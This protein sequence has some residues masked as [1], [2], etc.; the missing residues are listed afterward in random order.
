[1]LAALD[2][3]LNVICLLGIYCIVLEIRTLHRMS[4]EILSHFNHNNL[5][6][7]KGES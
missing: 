1:M 2:F 6:N 4:E 7:H 3:A 5:T